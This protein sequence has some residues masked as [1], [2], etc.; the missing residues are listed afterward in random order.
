LIYAFPVARPEA[1]VLVDVAE[2]TITT[3]IGDE[4]AQAA[5]RLDTYEIIGAIGVRPLLRALNID[6]GERRLAELGPPQKTRQINRRGRTLRITTALL[7]RGCGGLSRPFG[8]ERT[9]REYLRSGAH[10]KLRRRLEADAKSL[11]ALYQ[12]GR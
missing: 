5:R 8:N 3:L 11:Y 12:Y 6:P 7:F 4:I 1:L 9:M 2:R 10:I